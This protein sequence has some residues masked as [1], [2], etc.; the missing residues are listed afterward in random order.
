VRLAT[1]VLAELAHRHAAGRVHGAVGARGVRLSDGRAQLEEAGEVRPHELAPELL[2]GGPPT[3]S[4]DLFAVGI[5]LYRAL[6]GEFPFP[7]QNLT[8]IV[9][10]HLAG[11]VSLRARNPKVPPALA[12]VIECALSRRVAGRPQ[13]APELPAHRPEAAV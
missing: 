13:S 5:L 9:D 10:S 2:E 1:D 8:E 4:S 7:G 3:V 6:T 12:A 11:P